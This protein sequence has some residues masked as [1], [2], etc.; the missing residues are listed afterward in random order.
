MGFLSSLAHYVLPST[1]VL[2]THYRYGWSE[3]MVGL[4][5]AGVGLCAA[6][7]QG[8]LVRPIVARIGERRALMLG[9]L[10]GAA[11]FAIYGIAPTGALFWIGVPVMSLWGIAGPAT[12]GLMTRRVSGSEQGQLQGAQSSIVGIAGLIGPLLFTLTFAAFIGAQRN[13]QLPGAPFLL[14][15]ILLL[16]GT[17]V[18]WRVTRVD[19]DL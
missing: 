16:A 5:L 6:I 4:T 12:Q 14:A 13:W 19:H 15:A 18:A 9:L 7:V 2:Y 17:F 11:G 8:G 3:T 10:F 1:F